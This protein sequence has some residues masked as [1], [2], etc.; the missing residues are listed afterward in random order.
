MYK[1]KKNRVG[2]GKDNGN[3]RSRETRCKPGVALDDD[4]RACSIFSAS[5]ARVGASNRCRNGNST[6]NDLRTRAS[7]CVPSSEWPPHSKKLSSRLICVTPRSSRQISAN[8]FS[9]SE[10]ADVSTQ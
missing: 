5:A 10:R 2:R 4:E 8:F 7:N 9:V 1:K 6:V 3:E